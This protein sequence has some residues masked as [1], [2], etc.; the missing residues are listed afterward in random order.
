MKASRTIFQGGLIVLAVVA[1]LA[2]TPKFVKTGRK[3]GKEGMNAMKS[4]FKQGRK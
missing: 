4:G 1:A 2:M 3:L